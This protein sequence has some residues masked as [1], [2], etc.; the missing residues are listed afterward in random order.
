MTE[1]LR[2]GIL[3]TGRITPR[4]V[5]ALTGSPRHGVVAV[6]SRDS[7]R[8]AAYAAEHGLSRSHAS[9][10][11]LLADP[12]VDAIYVALPNHLHVEWTIRALEAGKHVL[13]EKPLALSVEDVDRV[14]AA[15][16]STDRVAVEAF[17]YLHHPQTHRA[18]ELVAGG[19]LGEVQLVRGAFSFVLT[20]PGDPRL[21][22]AMG[23]GSLWDVGGYPISFANR[24]AGD[25]PVRIDAS[26]R[27]GPTG[28]DLRASAQLRY[29]NG[30]VAQVFS[31][32]ETAHR[33]PVEIVG[34]EATL[35]L[36]PAF[37]PHLPGIDTTIR[38]RSEG[39]VFEEITV[40]LADPYLAE[41]NNLA[42]VIAGSAEPELP[43]TETRRNIAT[44][45]DA[46]A[47]AEQAAI[48]V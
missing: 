9:Y 11:A 1:P 24:I 5:G 41:A 3:G 2:W 6:G 7:G 35:M 43:L 16:E 47:A 17:M 20:H 42:D 34:S 33:E 13:C 28:V 10:E 26:T 18:L 32:F 31:S 23:G 40:P 29:Q 25:R 44:I 36:E 38:I 4:L 30:I 39:D 19:R 27:I 45:L 22:P 12:G 46:Y 8:S 37:V 48:P 21:E 15:T 14:I